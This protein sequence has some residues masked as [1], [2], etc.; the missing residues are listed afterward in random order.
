MPEMMVIIVRRENKRPTTRMVIAGLLRMEF[1]MSMLCRLVT[2]GRGNRM[3]G[4]YALVTDSRTGAKYRAYAQ[5]IA[6]SKGGKGLRQDLLRE[7]E[8]EKKSVTIT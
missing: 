2:M 6:R 7:L 3:C 5:A 1:T 4:A 8:G